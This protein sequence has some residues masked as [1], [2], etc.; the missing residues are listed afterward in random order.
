MRLGRHF[1]KVH[2][3]QCTRASGTDHTVYKFH[4]SDTLPSNQVLKEKME[5]I[6]L[7]LS[8]YPGV[9][10]ELC[11]WQNI[12]LL[13]YEKSVCFTST[14]INM[15]ISDVFLLQYDWVTFGFFPVI[16]GIF[17]NISSVLNQNPPCGIGES[18]H[19]C[20][21]QDWRCHFKY[22]L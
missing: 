17:S 13:V 8:S 19:T 21:C 12:F 2:L 18:F 16:T 5:N 10:Q 14:L 22:V 4:V 15:F 1:I 6:I 3:S 11:K 20:V 9:L 7:S